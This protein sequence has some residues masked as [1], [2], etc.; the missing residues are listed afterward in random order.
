MLKQRTLALLLAGSI[1]LALGTTIVAADPGAADTAAPTPAQTEASAPAEETPAVEETVEVLP[2]AEGTLSF[3]NLESR[4]RAGSLDLLR[5]QESINALEVLDYEEML[6]DARDGVNLIADMQWGMIDNDPTGLGIGSMMASSMQSSYAAAKAQFDA[7]YDGELQAD[8]E[9][10]I[11]QLKN[12]QNQVVMMGETLYAGLISLDYSKD[13]LERR[14]AALDR[15]IQV[16]EL[17]HQQGNVSALALQEAKAGR[18]ALVSGMETVKMNEATLKMQLE[19]LVGEALAGTVLLQSV[20]QV[21]AEEIAAMNMEADYEAAKAVSYELFAAQRTLDDAKETFD[22]VADDYSSTSK[23]YNYLSAKH[24]WQSAQYTYDAAVESYELK[25]KTLYLQTK[26]YYQAWE[27]AKVALAAEE[28]GFAAEEIKFNQGRI[29]Q[30][31][32]YDARDALATA[33]EK[34]ATTG[35]DLFTSYNNYRWAVDHGILN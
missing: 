31:A 26:D 20:P 6:E 1:T 25:F 22:E 24:R 27:A 9:A 5:V 11:R 28:A 34:V 35:L 17:S 30:N 29:S 13:D 4:M 33:R 8:N 12:A 16:A 15:Q 2:D 32:F 23:N 14:L 3:A 21:T 10:L 19:S 18:A 7:I